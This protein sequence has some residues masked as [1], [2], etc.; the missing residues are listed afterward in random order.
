MSTHSVRIAFGP[1]E[2]LGGLVQIYCYDLDGYLI[3]FTQ[4][5]R[6]SERAK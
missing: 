2:R 6:E 3:G 1:V 4:F 5:A